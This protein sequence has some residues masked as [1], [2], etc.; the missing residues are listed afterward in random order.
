M[1]S[2]LYPRGSTLL[3]PL[4]PLFSLLWLFPTSGPS[5]VFSTFSQSPLCLLL[6][7]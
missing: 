7:L 2:T 3:L 4:S 5:G 6:T 1:I